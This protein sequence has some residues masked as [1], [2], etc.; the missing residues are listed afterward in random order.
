MIG[1]DLARPAD[2]KDF[3]NQAAV[4]SARERGT[5]AP[6]FARAK[7]PPDPGRGRSGLR[8]QRFD[9]KLHG[10]ANALGAW[11]RGQLQNDQVRGRAHQGCQLLGRTVHRGQLAGQHA[12]QIGIRE[13]RCC[14]TPA[15]PVILL[16]GCTVRNPALRNC[17]RAQLP[18]ASS[19]G[20]HTEC[21]GYIRGRTAGQKLR[22]EI[23]DGGQCI[24]VFEPPRAGGVYRL[25]PLVHLLPA[26]FHEQA[27]DPSRVAGLFATSG[28]ER[29]RR[30]GI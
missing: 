16:R 20:G 8:R 23:L 19:S 30:L 18:C 17:I 4:P 15:L 25:Q 26:A 21:A 3:R 13:R 1:P 28:G 22:H 7:H 11:K 9:Q 14:C 10:P 2:P 29:C 6:Q 12:T 27:D 24:E 5:R